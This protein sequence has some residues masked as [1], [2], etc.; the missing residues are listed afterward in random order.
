MGID[1]TSPW[2]PSSVTVVATDKSIDILESSSLLAMDPDMWYD[3]TVDLVYFIGGLSNGSNVPTLWGFKPQ[4]NGSVYWKSQSSTMNPE[5]AGLTSNITGGLSATSP[6]AHYN[7]GGY[8]YSDDG[9][10]FPLGEMLSYNSG[11]QSWS[12]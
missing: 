11:N 8:S 7:L 12:N 5:S 1:L 2:T 3:P 6:T 10:G 9:E 4:S